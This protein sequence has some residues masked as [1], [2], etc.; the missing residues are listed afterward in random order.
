MRSE[1][2]VIDSANEI[3]G[4]VLDHHGVTRKAL[5]DRCG[6]DLSTISRYLSGEKTV[7]AGV[8]R[9]AFELTGDLRLLRLVI[10]SVPIEL[11]PLA[12]LPAPA[13]PITIQAL[14]PRACES[15]RNAVTGVEAM[16]SI[17]ADGRVDDS[18]RRAIR[19]FTIAAN[20]AI[21]DLSLLTSAMA[22][23]EGASAS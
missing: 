6:R 9:A 13:A 3:L 19:E 1:P 20:A 10:G 15:A 21:R 18:D 16:A 22:A 7:P 14:L 8:L 5:R 11:R 2:D 12:E 17:V 23:Y 4:E